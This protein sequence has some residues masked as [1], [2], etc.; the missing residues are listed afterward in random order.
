MPSDCARATWF[1]EENA[2]LRLL[3]SLDST[4]QLEFPVCVEHRDQFSPDFVLSSRHSQIGL[5]V[6][7]A[8]DEELIRGRHI[9]KSHIL[10]VLLM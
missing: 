4:D 5:E 3:R 1:S 7:S 9:L 10:H 6:T 2:L 8:A